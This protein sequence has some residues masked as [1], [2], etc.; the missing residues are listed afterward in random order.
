MSLTTTETF[1]FVD[2]VITFLESNKPALLALGLDVTAWIAE[3]QTQKQAA[4]AK[5]NE[6]EAAKAHLRTLTGAVDGLLGTVYGNTS[7]KLDAAIG[8]IGKTTE[9]GKQAARLRSDIRR[10]PTP[11]PPP[12]ATP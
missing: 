2:S 11:V 3:L 12:P 8:V 4:V 7:T 5:N 1:G 6:Q 9:L 10:G